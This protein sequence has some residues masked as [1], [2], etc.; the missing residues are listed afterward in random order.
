[1]I[2]GLPR[3]FVKELLSGRVERH[4][5]GLYFPR[6]RRV[7]A[8]FRYFLKG[9][10]DEHWSDL[11]PNLITD[12]GAA[13]ILDVAL[14]GTSPVTTW[15]I[16]PFSN[17]VSPT[18]TLTSAT[19]HSTLNELNTEYSEANRVAYVEAGASARKTTN[20]ASPAV[21]TSASGAVTIWGAGLLSS[22]TKRS[23]T[24]PLLSVRKFTSAYTL[25]STSSTVALTLEHELTYISD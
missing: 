3:E 1:M 12:E 19:F 9:G 2:P 21:F 22:A 17:N 13:H 14:H 4:P 7:W 24:A 20:A 11:G 6:L 16:A 10:D 15:Y 8:G 18:Q 5:S 23:T 25:P